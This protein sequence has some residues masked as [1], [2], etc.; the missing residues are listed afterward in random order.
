MPKSLQYRCRRCD[1]KW[2]PQKLYKKGKQPKKCPNC[3]DPHWDRPYLYKTEGKT[4]TRRDRR[5]KKKEE[6]A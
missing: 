2:L 6:A 4:R 5:L 1:H 3:S